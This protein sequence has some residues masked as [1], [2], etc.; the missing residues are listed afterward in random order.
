LSSFGHPQ[1]IP[2]LMLFMVFK[3]WNVGGWL[4][5]VVFGGDAKS[6]VFKYEE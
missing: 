3:V 6:D 1:P 2:K 5:H 4:G